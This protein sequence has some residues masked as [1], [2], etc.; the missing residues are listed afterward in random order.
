MLTKEKTLQVV[1]ALPTEFTLNELLDKLV[2]IM[3]IEHAMEQA[4]MGQ[5]VS[6]DEARKRFEKW[7]K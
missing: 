1:H 4:K 6:S 2:F 7:L 5:V 3:E